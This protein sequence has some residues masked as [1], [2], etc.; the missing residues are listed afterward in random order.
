MSDGSNMDGRR[1]TTGGCK[2]N[3]APY[4][5]G[6]LPESEHE[7]FIRHMEAC[8]VCREEVAA[9]ETVAAA[10]PGA[11][12]QLRAPAEI[13]ARV[14]AEVRE[15]ARR[16]AAAQAASERPARARPRW[17]WRPVLAAPLAAALA[18][19]AV[20]VVVASGG[21]G[22]PATRVI[23]AEVTAPGASAYVRISDEHADLTVSKF[24]PTP[25]GRVYEV[26]LKR[27]GSPEATDALFTVTSRGEATV[28][29]P[30]SV[31]GVK[32]VMV[33]SEPLGGSTVPTT[34]PSIIAH[35]S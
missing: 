4:V 10:L 8:A 24:P 29:V 3:A 9:L 22:G 23:R 13:K 11:A 34:A 6:A 21:S 27:S 14:M 17:A 20:V 32:A 31:R 18:V 12:P 35:L 25:R 33:T 26:W 19:I 1:D 15:D 2:G 30:G 7:D 5:L 16:Q 28:V